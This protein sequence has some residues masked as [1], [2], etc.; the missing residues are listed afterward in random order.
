MRPLALNERLDGDASVSLRELLQG[1][2][3]PLAGETS[4]GLDD[5]VDEI[6][7]SGFP[8]LRGISD[9]ALRLQLDGYIERIVDR[10]FPELGHSVRPPVPRDGTLLGALFESLVTLCVRVYA[11]SAEARVGHLR[12]F[13][14]DREV[15]LIVE[16]QDN[17][18]VAIEVKLKRTVTDDDA[19]NLRWLQ[20]KIGDELLDALIVTS[21]ENA[22]RA[23]MGSGR[24][25]SATGPVTGTG[26]RNLLSRCDART[27]REKSQLPGPFSIAGVGSEQ[28]PPSGTSN[29]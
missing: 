17:R 10:D 6:L 12:T 8:G 27:W 1:A 24:A 21:G 23:L 15:D 29:R 22:Y 25:G 18:V 20:S 5:Y 28:I 19:R 7:A 4:I 3:P 9:R 11:Q 14:G 26:P 16:T 13:S 2:R